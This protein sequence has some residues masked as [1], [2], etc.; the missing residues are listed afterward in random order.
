MAQSTCIWCFISPEPL[1]SCFLDDSKPDKIVYEVAQ[2]DEVCQSVI[3]RPIVDGHKTVRPIWDALTVFTCIIK[4]L[5]A[6]R[7]RFEAV[8]VVADRVTFLEC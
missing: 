8:L 5:P 3:D 2:V 6:V 7:I 1:A 4:R